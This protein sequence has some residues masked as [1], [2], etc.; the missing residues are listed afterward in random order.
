MGADTFEQATR[1]GELIEQN[2]KEIE[3]RWLDRVQAD[4]AQTPGV[5]LTQLRDGMPAYL[6]SLSKLLK[7]AREDRFDQR[8]RKAWA[9]IA[10]EHGVTRVRIGF[11]IRELVHEFVV[12]RKA[13]REV[14]EEH[15]NRFDLAQPLLADLLDAAIAAAVQAYVDARDYDGRRRQAESIGFLTHELKNPLSNAVLAAAQLRRRVTEEQVAL[16]NSLERSHARLT[17]LIDSVLLT[18]Q[19]ESGHVECHAVEME[20]REVVEEAL[21]AARQAAE[22][23]GLTF[24]ATY[25]PKLKVRLDKELTRSA[26]QNVADN[27]AKYTDAGHVE[28]TVERNGTELVFHVTDTC[29]GL[30]QEELGTIFEPFERGRTV[31]SG[32]GLGLAIA[33]RAIDAQGGE[34]HAESPNVVG[35]HFWFSLPNAAL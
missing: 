9:E 7:G 14:S 4:I 35:C 17:E 1:L 29:H 11:D 2:G 30:S 22:Q 21:Q 26:L 18:Q 33:R 5:S 32:T 34:I 13:I 12:L 31:K 25:D 20:L 16:V 10:R 19:L 27:A 24:Q 23:K 8:G 3:R 6:R 28:V 15:G